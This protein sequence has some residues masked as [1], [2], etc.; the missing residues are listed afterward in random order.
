[1]GEIK[2]KW[3]SVGEYARNRGSWMHYNIER[4]LNGLSYSN[5]IKEMEQFLQFKYDFIDQHHIIPYRTEWRIAAPPLNI[6]GSVDFIGKTKND[7][8]IMLD[9][10][11]AK[12]L[13]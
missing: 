4:Y 13:E 5:S 12:D 7:E 9:W 8:Y 1:M 6:A 10:K 3:A 11:R 2:D